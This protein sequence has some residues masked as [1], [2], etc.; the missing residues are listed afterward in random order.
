MSLKKIYLLFLVVVLVI[1][2]SITVL[3]SDSE[4][5]QSLSVAV[6]M[7]YPA[8]L[9][10]ILYAMLSEM[11]YSININ[12]QEMASAVEIVNNGEADILEVQLDGINRDYP[13]LVK[14]EV[15][16][17]RISFN[18]YARKGQHKQ[19]KAWED[20]SGKSIGILYEKPHIQ[21][22]L[23]SGVGSVMY[24]TNLV[25]L[26]TAL[27]DSEI[28]YVVT[29]V[30][31]GA[32]IWV[33]E[34]V[35]LIRTLDAS[36]AYIYVNKKH[37][38]LVPEMEKILRQMNEEGLTERILS[39]EVIPR[40]EGIDPD[41]AGNTE[42]DGKLRIM[43]I[44]SYNADTDW[45]QSF[46]DGL[47]AELEEDSYVFQWVSLNQSNFSKDGSRVD[48]FTDLIRSEYYNNMP[49]YI[50]VSDEIAFDFVRQNYYTLF[51]NIP[52]AVF[53]ITECPPEKMHQ[54]VQTFVGYTEQYPVQET[55]TEALKM[56]P[57]TKRI[58]VINDH[59]EPGMTVRSI[60]SEK[61]SEL[62]L[63]VDIY[64]NE[65]TSVNE[66]LNTV[67]NLPKDTIIV[68]GKY[69]MDYTD[70]HFSEEE[71]QTLLSEAAEVPIFGLVST[72]I[73]YGQLGGKYIDVNAEGKKAGELIN[74]IFYDPN[75][76]K[77]QII[78]D[79]NSYQW[80]FDQAVMEHY[81]IQT[82]QLPEDSILLNPN[83]SII[84]KYPAEFKLIFLLALLLF[85]VAGI[86]IWSFHSVRKR[87]QALRE[88]Q[89]NLHSA[90]ELLAREREIDE[91]KARLE[92]TIASAPI[93]YVRSKDGI[94]VESNEY[95]ATTCDMTPGIAIETLY[96]DPQE[97]SKNMEYIRENHILLG[98]LV[99]I[100]RLSGETKRILANFVVYNENI[101]D[102]MFVWFIDVE[103]GERAKDSLQLV[104]D[105]LQEL[106][107]VLPIPIMIVDDAVKE[108][109][110][111]NDEMFQLNNVGSMEELEHEK[112]LKRF[113]KR[114]EEDEDLLLRVDNLP[115]R[116]AE[117]GQVISEYFYSKPGQE[118]PI[119]IRAITSPIVYR[120]KSAYMLIIQDIDAEEKQK[121]L[122]YNAAEREKYAN[123]MKSRFLINMSHEI[124]T[125]MNAIVSLAEIE[126]TKL[127]TRDM[128]DLFQK[129]KLSS[130]NLLTIID[131]ILDF[132]KIEA[133]ELV[134]YIEEI[135]LEE[136]LSGAL[137]MASQRV[138]SKMVEILLKVDTEVPNRIYADQTR[139]WQILKNLLDNSAKYT[140][141][142]I[143]EL[144]VKQV[145]RHG[146]IGTFAFIISDTGYGMT[147]EQVDRL[148]LPYEQFHNVVEYQVGSGI[149]MTITKQLIDL[150]NGRIEVSSKIGAGTKSTVTIPFRIPP[151]A[152][153][154]TDTFTNAWL[155]QKRVLIVDDEP[156]SVEIMTHIL[157]SVG[158]DPVAVQ[159]GDEAI[160]LAEEYAANNQYFNI[161]IVDYMMQEKNGIDTA[162]ELKNILGGSSTK[163]LMVSA[164]VK[165]LI[166]SEIRDAGF[167]DIIEK[168]FCPSEF[169]RKLCDAME[170]PLTGSQEHIQFKDA[171]I[172]LCED[173]IINQEVAVSVLE[174]FGIEP[175]VANN[176]Q[177]GIDLLEQQVF[178][179]VLMDI[180]MPV[181]DGHE[182]TQI[183]RASNKPYANI[184]II[185]VT[186]NVMQDEVQKCI[187]EGMNAHVGK[188]ISIERLQ[189]QLVKWLPQE[190]LVRGSKHDADLKPMSER[191]S[192]LGTEI[193][194]IS[195][196]GRFINKDERYVL[197]LLNFAGHY[198]F[199]DYELCDEEQLRRTVHDLKGIAG[200][201]GIMTVHHLAK[202]YEDN[203][204]QA[205]YDVLVKEYE[206]ISN[207]IRKQLN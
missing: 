163:L 71:F 109:L 90:E 24:E 139:L 143:I 96:A 156:I 74:Q 26:Q 164:Y 67:K 69:M 105:E 59:T 198:H 4:E 112:V 199:T 65:K 9:D 70:R 66:L 149:G 178:D 33:P 207:L 176:G 54:F 93:G 188:P 152:Q 16:I 10:R 180:L 63:T 49:N 58:F 119:S 32:T 6:S 161:I 15:P 23:P 41:A 50:I 182:A 53:G 64:Y 162:R 34:N 57:D 133:E 170:A 184:P 99:T 126:L 186:A 83:L 39:S 151:A 68:C 56:F 202:R 116:V 84:E 89:K 62:D 17:G 173:N 100:R 187:D 167:D 52:V 190:K 174:I 204:I 44:T 144:E 94:C 13:N 2:S 102:D 150:M 137:L 122:L 145:E 136:V 157:N 142:G 92:K 185:A 147:Q 158:I 153:K 95:A 78:S 124:R 38:Y 172:L 25:R 206:R 27:S 101:P 165:Q 86:T 121:E 88:T 85:V 51:E 195:G 18:V 123:E 141:A 12:S 103:E 138:G 135:E 148:F 166:S 200:N 87:T 196:R 97:R 48:F 60:M 3:A 108:V 179:L 75:F 47:H 189:Q 115:Q 21:A 11:G 43:H 106:L 168:P 30:F 5:E 42:P 160:R 120:G 197:A 203:P 35:E 128:V 175:V 130:K 117:E 73:G 76:V 61:L 140:Q 91:V 118:E 40:G 131:D 132:S 193:D 20:F 114:H 8:S 146:D 205:S 77:M 194:I 45:V 192:L 7:D 36:D 177:E 104:Q 183:I 14:V 31:S 125:P 129:I 134:I 80:M 82:R 55:I 37:S 29:P 19:I 154:I 110:Y 169:I 28:D 46:R 159:S 98:R 191:L 72:S 113:R 107:S 79:T 201:L 22:K 155:S 181:M 171:R 127:H 1:S 81:G 111:A